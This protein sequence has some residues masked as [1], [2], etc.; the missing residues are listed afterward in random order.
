MHIQLEIPSTHYLPKK[1]DNNLQEVKIIDVILFI[2]CSSRSSNPC[3]IENAS[4]LFDNPMEFPTLPVLTETL[5]D[6]LTSS[7]ALPASLPAMRRHVSDGMAEFTQDSIQD[8]VFE[9]GL[10]N[11]V[12]HLGDIS[13]F[14]IQFPSTVFDGSHH[15]EGQ[16]IINDVHQ[17]KIR[18]SC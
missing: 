13:M 2:Y 14:I 18:F 12:N 7:L 5:S 17:E 9:F 4:I 15:F 11:P 3:F 8:K 6:S 1:N 10:I 16:F